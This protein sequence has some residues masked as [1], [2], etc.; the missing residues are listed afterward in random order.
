MSRTISSSQAQRTKRFGFGISTIKLF[1]K[2]FALPSG[3]GMKAKF[4][5]SQ[6]LLMERRSLAE[7]IQA[8]HGITPSPF[9]SSIE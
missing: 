6:S 7:A 9:I 5:P 2:L 3:Q 4:L 8:L 1:Q